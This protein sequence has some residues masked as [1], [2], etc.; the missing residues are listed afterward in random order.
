M[1]ENDDALTVNAAA[2]F[3]FLE[4][5]LFLLLAAVDLL[6]SNSIKIKES[7][8]LL[9]QSLVVLFQEFKL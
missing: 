4:I 8:N 6:H 7:G 9:F 1:L 2:I 3:R 5:L